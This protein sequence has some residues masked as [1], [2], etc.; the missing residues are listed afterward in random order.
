MGEA[1]TPGRLAG[2]SRPAGA[3]AAAGAA[4]NA[5]GAAA[6]KAAG[7]AAGWAICLIC[8]DRLTVS[9]SFSSYS[10]LTVSSVSSLRLSNSASA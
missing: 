9:R 1:T 3:A 10:R 6:G 4:A 8:L 7:A 5:A 2:S